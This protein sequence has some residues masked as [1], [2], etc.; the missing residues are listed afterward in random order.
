MAN[1][2][3]QRDREM[4][5]PIRTI[6]S[7]VDG[8]LTDGRIVYD[9]RGVETKSFHVRDGLGVKLWLRAGYHF[10]II[11]TRT[12]DVVR[13]RAAELGIRTVRQGVPDK[14]I[15]AKEILRELGVSPAETCYI[16]D[17]LPDLAVMRQIALP[18]AVGDAAE[19]VRKQARWTTRLGGG[20]GAVRELIERLLKAKAQW[21]DFVNP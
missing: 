18:V 12:S 3:T 1:S 4:A 11:T 21:E 10:A 6:L 14:W 5:A 16:G 17:D 15:A 8:V 2:Q 19:D 20:Q 13:L 7:D 9:N